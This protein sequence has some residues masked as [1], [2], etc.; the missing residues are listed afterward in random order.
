MKFN[1]PEM[2]LSREANADSLTALREEVNQ[3]GK[4]ISSLNAE[5]QYLSPTQSRAL[6][7]L[8]PLA[9]SV[10]AN[11][12]NA[13]EYFDQNGVRMPSAVYQDYATHVYDD[14]QK[15]KQTLSD[16]LKYEKTR[17]QEAKLEQRVQA[18]GE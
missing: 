16:Y 10:A 9:Q 6:D 15:I 2:R 18:D 12:E 17:N 11:T 7:T 8:V 14:S 1:R 5:R 3:M 4:V 13:I